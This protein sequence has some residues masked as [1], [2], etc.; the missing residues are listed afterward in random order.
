MHRQRRVLED[1]PAEETQHGASQRELLKPRL[2][3]TLLW[4]SL[5]PRATNLQIER[6]IKR[7]S[8]LLSWDKIKFLAFMKRKKR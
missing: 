5:V 2:G 7:H 6:F 4:T 1:L 3:L 8:V